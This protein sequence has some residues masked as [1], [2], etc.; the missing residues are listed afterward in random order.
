MFETEV[1]KGE[2]FEFGKNWQSFLSTLTD[3]RIGVAIDSIKE[4]LQI[5]DLN[6]KK[7]LDVGSGSGL[8][9]LAFR[10]LGAEV[11]SFDYDPTSVACTK[12]LRSKFFQDDPQ[13]VVE[14]ASVLDKDFIEGLGQFDIVYS[15][16]VLHH[17]GDMWAAL[18][19]AASPVKKHGILFVGIYNDQGRASRFWYQVKKCYCSG[20]IGRMVICSVFIPYYFLRVLTTSIVTGHDRFA[21]YKKK[22]GMS[23]THDWFD[24]L[25]GFPFEVAKP[26]EIFHF[27]QDRGFR[28]TN[29]KTTKRGAGVNQFVFARE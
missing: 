16:G 9:S 26:E 18:D 5:D 25:G 13:W 27:Y 6:G 12:E 14:Q 10:K 29:L 21:A 7:V 19:N 4:M 22:R 3:E 28:L 23:I 17:T 20:T 1:K 11:H 24:W 2:R 8:F 15:W